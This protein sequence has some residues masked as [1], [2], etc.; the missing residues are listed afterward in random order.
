[1]T[2]KNTTITKTIV[3]S[4]GILAMLVSFGLTASA[5][6]TVG[7][8]VSVNADQ[9]GRLPDVIARSNTEIAARLTSL[10][11]LATR[12]AGMQNVPASEVSNISAE[13]QTTIGTLN[14]IKAK[15]DAD[16]DVTTARADEKTIFD[17]VRVYA[18]VIPQ[19]YDIAS[20][21]R[22]TT[23]VGL[24]NT[25]QVKLQTRVTAAQSAGQNVATLQADLADITA[26]TTDAT[27]QAASA[28]AS[29]SGLVPDQGNASVSASNHAALLAGAAD[30]KVASSD[31]KTADQDIKAVIS[32]LQAM[33]STTSSTT[34]T[35]TVT[36]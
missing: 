29:V 21:D 30:L 9:S 12:V 33:P 23:I 7:A 5:Q 36:Q 2:Y 6:T 20:S 27:S 35:T 19:G 14:G 11:T 28:Q 18:L 10:N 3:G 17:N 1:M 34:T 25:L 4:A 15:I 24:M 32:G 8:A 13:V 26:R 16:T 31:L 22:V